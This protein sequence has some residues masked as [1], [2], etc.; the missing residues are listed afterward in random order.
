M[1][2]I[3]PFELL[4]ILLLALIILGPSRLPDLANALGRSIREFRKGASDVEES[5]NPRPAPMQ[6]SMPAQAAG[7]TP[8]A[9]LPPNTLSTPLQPNTLSGA[10]AAEPAPDEAPSEEP[11]GPQ[12]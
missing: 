4:V 11:S 3:G 6:S 1:P 10:R 7:P 12:G 8:T 5:V 2:Q 9:P